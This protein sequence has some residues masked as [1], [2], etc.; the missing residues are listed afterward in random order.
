M[1]NG[2]LILRKQTLESKFQVLDDVTL[3]E[4]VKV[5]IKRRAV[6]RAKKI[7]K[8]RIY[9]APLR[10]PSVV[11]EFSEGADLPQLR[12]KEYHQIFYI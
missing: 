9:R 1:K 5:T 12:R 3:E 10:K 8:R 6:E 11:S 2:R 4:N 7:G